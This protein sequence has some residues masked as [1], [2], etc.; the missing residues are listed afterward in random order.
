MQ[1][2]KRM[3][4]AKE[5]SWFERFHRP[6]EQRFDVLQRGAPRVVRQSGVEHEEEVD[7]RRRNRSA[8]EKWW[9][10]RENLGRGSE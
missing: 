1:E 3:K 8:K 7:A 4:M 10:W 6:F 9:L 2:E 5:G